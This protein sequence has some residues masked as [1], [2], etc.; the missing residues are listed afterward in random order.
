[1]YEDCMESNKPKLNYGQKPNS[2]QNRQLHSNLS[3]TFE[4]TDSHMMEIAEWQK[5]KYSSSTVDAIT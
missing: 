4:Q 3:M 2:S 5:S 1:M